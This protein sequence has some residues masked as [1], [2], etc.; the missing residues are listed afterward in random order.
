MKNGFKELQELSEEIFDITVLLKDYCSQ[1]LDTQELQS[2][3]A[4][5]KLLNKMADDLTFKVEKL[6]EEN[7]KAENI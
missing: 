5:V 6:Q 2:I 1:N 3:H 7:P 4:C